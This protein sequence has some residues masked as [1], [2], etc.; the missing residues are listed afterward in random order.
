MAKYCTIS[1]LGKPI[2][3]IQWKYLKQNYFF[4]EYLNNDIR[5]CHLHVNE[6]TVIKL[7]ELLWNYF[8]CRNYVYVFLIIKFNLPF[9]VNEAFWPITEN[10]PCRFICCLCCWLSVEPGCCDDVWEKT[11]RYCRLE[12]LS[13]WYANELAKCTWR[14]KQQLKNCIL[15]DIPTLLYTCTCEVAL[16]KFYKLQTYLEYII[17]PRIDN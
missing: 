4:L 3:K 5:G 12:K 14:Q 15:L 2:L 16:R 13:W 1:L 6:N 7:K 11:W 9:T 10:V 8:K 17:S